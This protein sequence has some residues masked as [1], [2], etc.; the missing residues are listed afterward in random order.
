[1]RRVLFA[2]LAVGLLSAGAPAAI[3]GSLSTYTGQC[4][5]A[6]REDPTGLI[7]GPNEWIGTV[8]TQV[9][10]W[11]PDPQ[12]APVQATVSC[13][14]V[15]NG[16]TNVATSNAGTGSVEATDRVSYVATVPPDV[17][18]LCTVV[19]YTGPHD[20]TPTATSCVPYTV[21]PLF[22]SAVVGTVIIAS[23]PSPG[24][25]PPYV[26]A[27]DLA[28]PAWWTC[29]DNGL[30]TPFRVTC[31]PSSSTVLDWHCDVLAA[32]VAVFDSTGLARTSLDCDGGSPEAQ[33]AAVAGPHGTDTQLAGNAVLVN[34]YTCTVDDGSGGAAQPTWLATCM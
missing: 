11:S 24:Q 17:V 13:L 23:S 16:L 32:S 9:T 14:I 6:T 34:E 20:T 10:L 21:P 12:D 28:N 19:D 33:T 8:H 30:A 31:T 5:M 1:M 18:A 4:T 3:A 26:V 27:G 15:I 2:A 22:H 29:T 7:A 25:P